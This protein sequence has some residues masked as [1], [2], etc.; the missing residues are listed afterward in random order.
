MTRCYSPVSRYTVLR[1]VLR[2][3]AEAVA[4][5]APTS[6]AALFAAAIDSCL[7]DNSS[8]RACSADASAIIDARRNIARL[9]RISDCSPTNTPA[10]VPNKVSTAA[11]GTPGGV[12]ASRYRDRP[13]QARPVTNPKAA[14]H[15]L[16]TGELR[17][18]TG[19]VLQ[20]PFYHCELPLKR[21]YFPAV[22]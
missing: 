6:K 9:A 20:P 3:I 16:L 5:S 2:N 8:L 17:I 7:Q 19:A 14:P 1:P 15:E 18:A 22:F 12:A 4:G 13:R 10:L 21:Y 11:C